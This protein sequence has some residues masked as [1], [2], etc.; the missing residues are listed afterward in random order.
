MDTT[1]ER[2]PSAFIAGPRPFIKTKVLR[3]I[4]SLIDPEVK[5]T[6]DHVSGNPEAAVNRSRKRLSSRSRN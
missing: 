4:E 1:E 2:T 3:S 5:V 6:L